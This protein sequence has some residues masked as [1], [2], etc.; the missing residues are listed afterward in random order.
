VNAATLVTLFGDIESGNVH[1]VA[2]VL[3]R[4]GVPYRRVDVA[5]TRGEP[6]RPEYLALNPIGKVP[7]ARLPDGDVLTESGALLYWF[8]SGTELWPPGER[9][10][11]EVLR[12]MF[13]EQYSHEPALATM[14]YLRRSTARGSDQSA[15]AAELAPRAAWALDV[16]E[17]QLAGRSFIAADACTLADVALYPYTRWADEAGVDL[18]P[19]GAVRAWLARVE[20]E[21]RFLSLRAEGAVEVLSFEQYFDGAGAQPS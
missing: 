15:P 12:W 14:R 4:A 3:H 11:A 7:A 19:Y 21:P 13:F 2:M 5:Q 8:G 10:R 6:R 18:A 9:A 1:K 17:R 16:M 20:A